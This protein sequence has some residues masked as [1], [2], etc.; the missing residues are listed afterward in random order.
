V[1]HRWVP[2]SHIAW[3]WLIQPDGTLSHT[4]PLLV[5]RAESPS[6]HA[7]SVRVLAMMCTSS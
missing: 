3:R 7:S 6:M 2:W 4:E 1:Q 5:G